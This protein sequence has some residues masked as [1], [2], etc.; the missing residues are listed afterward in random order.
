M[1]FPARLAL[2]LG[3]FVPVLVTAC[4]D[5]TK[6]DTSQD[7][8]HLA[9]HFDSLFAEVGDSGISSARGLALSY[10]EI[11]AA[12][13]A[14]PASV[15]VT[16]ADGTE[17][18]KG[19]ELEEV[20]SGGC[21]QDTSYLILA[22]RDSDVHTVLLAFFDRDG[23]PT[24]EA[25]LI[26]DTVSVLGSLAQGST[27]RTSLGGS[28]TTISSA[29]TNPILGGLNILSCDLAGFETS[30]SLTSAST[31]GLDPALTSLTID[32]QAFRGARV[33]DEFE[34]ATVRRAHLLLQ[35]KPGAKRR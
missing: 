15:T 23:A 32:A 8:A 11:S 5:S 3:C 28:C 13:G 30:L 20:T 35:A 7:A 21:A 12:L 16:T 29:L 17:H 1:R 14:T 10:L 26:S 4:S 6:P 24:G 34:A 22:Y 19:Y 25:G 9:V 18:W 31:P 33:V 2:A 27:A